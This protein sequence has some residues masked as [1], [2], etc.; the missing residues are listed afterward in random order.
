M[1]QFYEP[2]FGNPESHRFF[3]VATLAPNIKTTH[4]LIGSAGVIMGFPRHFGRNFDAFWDCIRSLAS[5]PKDVAL[6]HQDIPGV[7]QDD[8]ETY[9]EL[10][11]DA[12]LYWRKHAAEHHLEV[13]FPNSCREKI[14]GIMKTIPLPEED[15][16][17]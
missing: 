6:V 11:R 15:E 7:E 16:L 10:L 3:L 17:E 4:K 14:D 5:Q 2:P 12:I 8:L 1:F 13:W 9:L